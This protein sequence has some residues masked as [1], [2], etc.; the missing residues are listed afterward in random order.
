MVAMM[1][2]EQVVA[3]LKRLHDEVVEA[4]RDGKGQFDLDLLFLD[5]L[6]ACGLMDAG[7][8]QAVI[9]EEAA[10][11]ALMMIILPEKVPLGGTDE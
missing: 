4:G 10:M 9:G 7:H 5:I 11:R 6:M 3:N 8:L 1:A 2:D